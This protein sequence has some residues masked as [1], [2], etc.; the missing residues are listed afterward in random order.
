MAQQE[1]SD[2]ELAVILSLLRN[3]EHSDREISSAIGM[4][5]FS[6]NKIK[7]SLKRRNKLRKYYI[8]DYSK[9]GFEILGV[10][11]GSGMEPMASPDQ[12]E[13]MMKEIHPGVPH[14]SIFTMIEADR[15]LMFHALK[16]FAA[17]KRAMR[18]KDDITAS[19]N[20]EVGSLKHVFFSF[21]DLRIKRFFDVEPLIEREIP[22]WNIPRLKGSIG[23]RSSGEL[24]S[25]DFG[26]NADKGPL[27]EPGDEGYRVMLEM[28]R[29]GEASPGTMLSR[30]NMS[31]YRYN[32]IRVQLLSSGMVRP[33][34]AMDIMS[35][36]YNVMIFSH[37]SVKGG[38]DTMELFERFEE[39]V[40]PRNLMIVA[41]DHSDLV[42]LGIF[43]DL[44][45]GTAA[46]ARM[47]KEMM[48][49][50]FLKREPEI[51]IFSLPN[52]EGDLSLTFHRPLEDDLTLKEMYE[53]GTREKN[54]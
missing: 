46:Q 25:F 43:R 27:L 44:S 41:F 11:Q 22:D 9:I 24:F 42:G 4:N 2:H 13:R 40:M 33:F 6:F 35:L 51:S 32:K 3:P 17:M 34:Y 50:G 54:G 28:V 8:P 1:F 7:N 21:R 12:R 48:E 15:G 19:R 30:L 39:E 14:H 36:G 38:V 16:D 20:I 49:M 23:G 37:I 10:S 26:K 53:Y 47:R 31:S 18:M 5:L 45:E 29:D 52:C